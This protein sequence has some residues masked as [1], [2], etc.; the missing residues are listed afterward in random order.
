MYALDFLVFRGRIG[1]AGPPPA[2]NS[3][4]LRTNT[5]A[6]HPYLTL[7]RFPAAPRVTPGRGSLWTEVSFDRYVCLLSPF[8][9]DPGWH[10]P[11][12]GDGQVAM[13]CADLPF[14]KSGAH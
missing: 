4:L 9:E 7:S 13:M 12:S 5:A 8:Q 10:D 14:E 6:F 2:L 11:L 3:T 1:G